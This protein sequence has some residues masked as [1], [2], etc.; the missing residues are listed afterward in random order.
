LLFADGR[1]LVLLAARCCR[2]PQPTR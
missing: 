2:Q 1:V